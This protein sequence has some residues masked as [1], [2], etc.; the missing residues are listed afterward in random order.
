MGGVEE[1]DTS[2]GTDQ[3]EPPAEEMPAGHQ[4]HSMDT[5]HRGGPCQQDTRRHHLELLLLLSSA[6]TSSP[7]GPAAHP[8]GS[9]EV[10][11]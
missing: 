2:P 3:P 8:E 1:E 11:A 4:E 9:E 7:A 6:S 10:S 5:S